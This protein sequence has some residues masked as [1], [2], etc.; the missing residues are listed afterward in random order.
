MSTSKKDLAWKHFSEWK[1]RSNAD[2]NE[3]VKCFT[4]EN[5]GHWK[6]FDTGHFASRI[7][8]MTFINETNCHPQCKYCNMHLHGNLGQYAINLDK[9]Y[10][11]G[12]AEYLLKKSKL[13][14]KMSESDW[15]ELADLYRNKLKQL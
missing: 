4:C 11:V 8:T 3:I 2:E 12:T 1:R 14:C 15:Q 9:M 6:T 7:H 10:G 13:T 5:T